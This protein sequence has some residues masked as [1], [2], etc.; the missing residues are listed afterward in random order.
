MHER[1]QPRRIKVPMTSNDTTTAATPGL[2]RIAP[3]LLLLLAPIAF[4]GVVAACS[5]SFNSAS[6]T[7]PPTAAVTVAQPTTTSAASLTSQSTVAPSTTTPPLVAISGFQASVLPVL[8]NNCASCHSSAG[9]GAAHLVLGTASDAQR[10][11]SFISS[12]V[13]DRY[14]PPWPAGDGDVKF[15]DDKRLTP[16]EIASL[17]DWANAGGPLDVDGDTPIAAARPSYALI[18]RD[19][20]LTGAPYL[21]STAIA[22]DYRCQVYDPQL[23]EPAYL[24]GYAIEADQTRVVHHGLVFAAQAS[25]RT[26]IDKVAASD[27]DVGWKCTGLTGAGG[28]G[29]V[30]QIMAWG[31]GQGATALPSDTAI[32]MEPGDFFIVQL[33]Y[34]YSKK[35]ADLPPDQSRLVVDFASDDVL[36]EHGGSL[37]P[38]T[39]QQYLGPAEIPCSNRQQ[40]P[41]CDRAAAAAQL[42]Q[43]FGPGESLIPSALMQQCG[44]KAED[45][46]G[47]T[48]GKASSTCDLPAVPGQVVSAWGHMHELGAT[49]RMTLNPGT[50]REKVLLDIPKWDF[51][52]QLNYSPIDEVII[53]DGDVVRVECSWDRSLSQSG[54]EP[55]YI[56]WSEG[57]ND[58]MCYSQIVTRPVKP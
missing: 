53:E 43:T 38:I 2:E 23:L 10:N 57:T 25:S 52:W 19:Q 37:D 29:N 54:R 21:G 27:P 9:P 34:H 40:G 20:V 32:A 28:L 41:L 3:R 45:F 39:L 6:S 24:Q 14:M 13:G 12:A 56:M 31:P 7:V 26:D 18:E 46:A 17:Q 11:A 8:E 58:E 5:S 22:D 50:S 35:T 1:T 33:H 47:F 4:G 55:R 36:A 15:H 49:F 16:D 30:K 44:V 48:D 51:D 42:E